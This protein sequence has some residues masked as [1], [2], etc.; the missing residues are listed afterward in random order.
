MTSQLH[1]ETVI[2]KGMVSTEVISLKQQWYPPGTILHFNFWLWDQKWEEQ[3]L[4]QLYSLPVSLDIAPTLLSKNIYCHFTG[5]GHKLVHQRSLTSNKKRAQP[6]LLSSFQ[7]F[8]SVQGTCLG[9]AKLCVVHQCIVKY[10]T[11]S[12]FLKGELR[13][14]ELKITK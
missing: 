5:A 3:N 13:Q 4:T 12:L 2:V 9:Q 6:S 11:S 10:A 14:L 8:R 7:K 1:M